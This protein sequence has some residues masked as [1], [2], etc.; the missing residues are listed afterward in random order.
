MHRRDLLRVG[1]LSLFGLSYSG[2]LRGRA[3]AEDVHLRNGLNASQGKLTNKAVADALRL[4]YTPVIAV[5][6]G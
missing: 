6:G 2:L 3:L 1:G 5:V 4:P